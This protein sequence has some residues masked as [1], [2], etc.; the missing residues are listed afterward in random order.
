MKENIFNFI[1]YQETH[2]WWFLART[3]ILKEQIKKYHPET[4]NNF[5]DVGCGTGF[6][7][8]NMVD[9]AEN[10]YGVDPYK[11][12]CVKID[13]II[14]G[15]VEDMPFEDNYFDFISCLD[16]LEHIKNPV[17]GLKSIHRVL[18]PGGYALITIPSCQFL[19]GPHDKDN[20]HVRR[21]SK[22][23]FEQFVGP[24]FEILKST[25]FNTLLFPLE[26]PI[27][28]LERI[29]N[30]PLT[31]GESSSSGLNNL[32]FKVFNME[33]KYLSNH[34]YPIGISYMIILKKK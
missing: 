12:D 31:K 9:H 2:H 8:S 3:N 32:F 22:K 17:D 19:Y 33:T 5:L 1:D 4:I 20:D 11:Y 16:V 27:R 26:A 14:Q 7:L 6:F 13:N 18:K 10:L 21:Y 30:K 34:N 24:E 29:V 28:I 15:V 25:Y 23:E